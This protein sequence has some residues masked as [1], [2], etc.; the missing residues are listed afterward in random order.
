[1]LPKP[2]DE[3]YFVWL[4]SQVGSVRR[5][6][7]ARTHWNLLRLLYTEPFTWWVLNDDNRAQDGVD[8]RQEFFAESRVGRDESWEVL[9]CDVL[10]LLVGL[11]RRLSFI[12]GETRE[13]W[14]WIMIENLGLYQ[15]NDS[16]DIPVETVR[17][18]LERLVC[19]TYDDDGNGGLFPLRN[20]TVDQ[21]KVELW[22]QMSEYIAEHE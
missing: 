1:M 19:R 6:N 5:R 22:Y 15:Y 18:V 13:T 12:T 7:P 9:E 17:D 2:L 10:E 21:R 20:P 11:S 3:S 14:F 16:V 8:L 4:Y